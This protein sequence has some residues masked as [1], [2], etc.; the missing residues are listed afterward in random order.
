MSGREHRNHEDKNDVRIA[1]CCL[2][3]VFGNPDAAGYVERTEYEIYVG[4]FPVD[5]VGAGSTPDWLG[6]SGSGAFG[7]NGA[8]CGGSCVDSAF[9][10]RRNPSG[11]IL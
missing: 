5:R 10:H 11:R 9:C 4:I 6:L 2:F 1:G 8:V 7:G 3:D